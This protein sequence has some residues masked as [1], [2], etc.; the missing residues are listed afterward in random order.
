MTALDAAANMLRE[1]RAEALKGALP[2][3]PPGWTA[4]NAETT[5]LSAA[6]LGGGTTASR[7]YHNGVQQ[8]DVQVTADNPMLQ[9]MAALIS[10]P[11]AASAGVKTVSVGGRP[12]SYTESDNGYMTLI[13]GKIILKVGGNRQTPEATLR[14]FVAAIDY[15]ALEK[16]AR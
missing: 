9:G 2:L 11:L 12:F 6:M 16:L 4:D 1:A 5:A 8:V 7:S 15:D 13:G 3:A 10:S 14:S